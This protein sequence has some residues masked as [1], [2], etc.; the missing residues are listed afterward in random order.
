L[1]LPPP[2]FSFMSLPIPGIISIDIIFEF[3]Y[4]S[5]QYLQYIHPPMPVPN[6]SP[7]LVPDPHSKTCSALLFS[8]FVKGKK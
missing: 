8:N 1:N 5:V 3:T 6:S 2:P 7:R 4:M